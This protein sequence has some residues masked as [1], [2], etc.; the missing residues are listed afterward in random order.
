MSTTLTVKNSGDSRT[1]PADMRTW[2]LPP[3]FWGLWPLMARSKLSCLGVLKSTLNCGAAKGSLWICVHQPG[4]NFIAGLASTSFAKLRLTEV[5]GTTVCQCAESIAR[6]GLAITVLRVGGGGE[7]GTN[8]LS[9]K[10]KLR[11]ARPL[12]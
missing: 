1:V 3:K 4:V 8:P 10:R 7:R 5:S 2:M 12:V 9:P 6:G 11:T